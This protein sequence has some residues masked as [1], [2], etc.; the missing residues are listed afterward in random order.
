MKQAM[1]IPL[2]DTESQCSAEN[3]L[4]PRSAIQRAFAN[5][6]ASYDQHAGLQRDVADQL[7]EKLP[8]L[9]AG[10][11]VLDLGCG[12]GY[13]T[14][15]LQAHYPHSSV[16]ALDLAEPMLHKVRDLAGSAH[17][18]C[19]DAVNLP[20][21]D[22]CVD[23]IVSSL[24]IQWCSDH[25][26]LFTELQRVL[27]P[28]G[29]ALL[30]TFGPRSLH[31]LRSA[32]AR[33]DRHVHVNSFVPLTE[34]QQAAVEAGLGFSAH[35]E[36]RQESHASLLA[37]GRALKGLGAHNMNRMQQQGL[38]SPQRFRLAARHFAMQGDAKGGIPVT[39][40]LYYLDISKPEQQHARA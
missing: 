29:R 16:V 11:T 25:L 32:W 17:L 26:R 5:A 9:D 39:W 8:A 12:T 6:A 33:V 18:L 7:L 24:T 28:G 23:L 38:T 40:E 2:Q 31:E 27:R 19:A 4:L 15:Q 1:A 37:L 22:A 21:R 13:C 3:A 34:L 10:S 36:L 35:S 30:S 20:L 14:G